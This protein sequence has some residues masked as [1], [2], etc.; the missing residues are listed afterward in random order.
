MSHSQPS[1]DN[2]ASEFA[3]HWALDPEV[4]FMNHG[5]F[6]ACPTPILRAQQAFQERMEREPMVFLMRELEKLLNAARIE[7]ADF[8]GACAD[9]LAF[10][11][12]TTCG[13][14][15]VLRS[16]AL[17]AGDELIVTD[18]EYNACRNA[19]E[20]VAERSGAKV[21]VAHI[22]FPIRSVEQVIEAVMECLTS[23]TRLALLDHITSP[24]GLIFP[25]ERL[26]AELSARGVDTLVDG[27]HA[28]GMVPLNIDRIG[29][30][31]FTGNCHKW[32]CAP[33][34]AALLHVRRD[35]QPA[36]RPLQISH[37]TSST[38]KDRSRFQLEFDWTG[39]SDP[40]PYLCV[41]E[42]IRF[43]GSL[44]PG[45]WPELMARNRA[46]ALVAREKICAWLGIAAPCPDEM[47]GT[48]AAFPLPENPSA[49]GSTVLPV[50]PLT[51]E[52]FER[53]R[54]EVVVFRFPPGSCRMLRISAQIY[55]S[56]RQYDR[57]V[58]ALTEVL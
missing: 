42:A 18:H 9:D 10:I 26:V 58:E 8:V 3:R 32:L 22:P 17:R 4:I 49:T 34:G 2:L 37:G 53:F 1:F 19:L 38:R 33:K 48:L 45:G 39:T 55:N 7:L 12:N 36:I 5:S 14:N 50:D 23:R 15:T 27:A 13:V 54:I 35:K 6:G 43:L 16:L 24:T 31:Y 56:P 21:V 25:I 11:P 29:A 47:V 40:A 30:A 52:L 51:D 41:P 28:P 46:L 20:F 44:L 57:L